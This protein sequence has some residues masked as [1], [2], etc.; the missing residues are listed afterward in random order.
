MDQ[1]QQ[2]IHRSRYA[3]YLPEEKRRETWEET[4]DRICNFWIDHVNSLDIPDE[5]K[6]KL[7]EVIG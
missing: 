3:R 2:Y 6:A 4:I 1:Y 7:L 5:N